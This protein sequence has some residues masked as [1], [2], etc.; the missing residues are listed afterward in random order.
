MNQNAVDY[1][2]NLINEKVPRELIHHVKSM[3]DLIPQISDEFK[4]PGVEIEKKHLII[5]RIFPKDIRN[6]LKILCDNNDFE[7]IDDI[8]EKYMELSS[9]PVL[10]S[11]RAKL[12]YVTAPSFEQLVSYKGLC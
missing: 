11:K 6:F 9:E 1:A 2:K 5:D 3:L 8:I 7:L 10:K 12:T 4:N